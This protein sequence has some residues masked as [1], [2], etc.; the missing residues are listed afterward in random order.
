MLLY[1]TWHLCQDILDTCLPVVSRKCPKSAIPQKQTKT[2][3]DLMFILM[4]HVF[5]GVR[6][7]NWFQSSNLMIHVKILLI[8][9]FAWLCFLYQ[10]CRYSLVSGCFFAFAVFV[11][12]VDDDDDDVDD[13]DDNYYT[14]ATSDAGVVLSGRFYCLQ[15]GKETEEFSLCPVSVQTVR[16]NDVKPG[17][18][19]HYGTPLVYI[20]FLGVCR[21]LISWSWNWEKLQ[22]LDIGWTMNYC[23]LVYLFFV[24]R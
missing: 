22:I 17:W 11:V 16:R 14:S 10:P 21:K 18:W 8:L 12:V 15:C 13:D 2:V 24:D 5:Y 20:C 1:K 7:H 3:P 6:K 23:C 9:C 19:I 4:Y